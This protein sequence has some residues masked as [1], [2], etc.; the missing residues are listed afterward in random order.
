MSRCYCETMSSLK[1][2]SND[3]VAVTARV[4]SLNEFCNESLSVSLNDG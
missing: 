2:G 3:S 1:E 4:S